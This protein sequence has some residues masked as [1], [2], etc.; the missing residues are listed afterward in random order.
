[1]IPPSGLSTVTSYGNYK[2]HKLPSAILFLLLIGLFTEIP[3]QRAIERATN[4][5][6]EHKIFFF[7]ELLKLIVYLT[8]TS[9]NKLMV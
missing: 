5:I 6:K 2:V 7:M 1:M 3:L 9:I 8:V 4:L